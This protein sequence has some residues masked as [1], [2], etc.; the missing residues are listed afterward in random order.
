MPLF[1]HATFTDGNI[2]RETIDSANAIVDHVRSLLVDQI[3]T[4]GPTLGYT[5]AAYANSYFQ[6]HMRRALEF[7]DGGMEEL[8]NGRALITAACARS[9]L[10]SVA[11]FHDFCRR[12][13]LILDEGDT[14]KALN[15]ITGQA[16]A[17]KLTQLHDQDRSNVATNIVTQLDRLNKTVPGLREVYDQLSE[18]THPNGLGAAAHFVHLDANTGVACFGPSDRHQANMVR[19]LGVAHF[20]GQMVQ[21]MRALSERMI[22]YIQDGEE[23]RRM[24]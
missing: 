16:F 4:R 8:E 17:T 22:A 24:D 12:L 20:L 13:T 15:F 6:A 14:V 19:L 1:D 9:I 5:V 11:C 3:D 18:V 23:A 10:E 2:D 21:D 7:L